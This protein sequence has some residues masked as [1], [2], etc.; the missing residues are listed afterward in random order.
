[1]NLQRGTI[2]VLGGEHSSDVIVKTIADFCEEK[3]ID[4]DDTVHLFQCRENCTDENYR[5]P[6]LSFM[7]IPELQ[8]CTQTFERNGYFYT[9]SADMLDMY[10]KGIT[11]ETSFQNLLYLIIDNIR[12]CKGGIYPLISSFEFNQSFCQ[13]WFSNFIDN[14]DDDIHSNKIFIGNE[15][16]IDLSIKD[17]STRAFV[18]IIKKLIANDHESC[19]VASYNEWIMNECPLLNEGK[20]YSIGFVDGTI[21]LDKEKI[22]D[23]GIYLVHFPMDQ[24]NLEDLIIRKQLFVSDV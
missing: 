21:S 9:I 11:P 22:M 8:L 16:H 4:D 6:E 24:K 19:T 7:Q 10:G 2:F 5:P 13:N 3:D 18:K 17:V 1:M 12:C 14:N 20:L 23:E 15:K